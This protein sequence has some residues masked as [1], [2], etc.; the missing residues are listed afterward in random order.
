[1]KELRAEKETLNV[2]TKAVWKDIFAN[3]EIR[4]RKMAALDASMN[5]E[6][7][8]LKW[9]KRR[10]E[11]ATQE[12]EVQ[13]AIKETQHE[14][15]RVKKSWKELETFRFNLESIEKAK[16]E[17]L[18]RQVEVRAKFDQLEEKEMVALA[19][20]ALVENMEKDKELQ[21]LN[22]QVQTLRNL[23]SE[24]EERQQQRE[25][26]KQQPQA[27]QQKEEQRK[28]HHLHFYQHIFTNPNTPSATIVA[29]PTARK[30]MPLK[31]A[32]QAES[33]VSV[34]FEEDLSFPSTI[35]CGGG[36]IG[37]AE[38]A[39]GPK[40]TDQV[41]SELISEKKPRG[42]RKFKFKKK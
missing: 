30:L 15:E 21:E 19:E 24:E 12:K 20:K 18:K 29:T 42:F 10:K 2:R 28:H 11:E 17:V 33:K 7:V 39:A 32:L 27:E 6:T 9:T 40:E 3:L 37:D 1:L 8:A 35:G 23:L 25:Q 31:P 41:T 38:G 26:Q 16:E 34:A 14:I 5:P 4:G 13:I 22:Y 36:Q